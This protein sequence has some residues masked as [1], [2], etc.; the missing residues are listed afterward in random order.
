MERVAKELH[1]RLRSAANDKLSVM[2]QYFPK[3]DHGD[4]LHLAAYR[5]LEALSSSR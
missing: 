2:F 3:L 4:T 1:E 5:A